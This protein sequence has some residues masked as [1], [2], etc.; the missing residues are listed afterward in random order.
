MKRRKRHTPMDAIMSDAFADEMEEV[1]NQ[2]VQDKL[3]KG[4]YLTMIDVLEDTLDMFSFGR[5]MF[6]PVPLHNSYIPVRHTIMP[7]PNLVDSQYDDLQWRYGR[8]TYDGLNLN[9]VEPFQPLSTYKM[10]QLQPS[11]RKRV[12]LSEGRKFYQLRRISQ[13]KRRFSTV[14]ECEDAD[15]ER[16]YFNE[17][18]QL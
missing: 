10:S 12:N 4:E 8:D 1:Y 9:P 13:I 3:A 14:V 6:G 5:K 18:L 15:Y 17:P 7:K 2:V 16:K 11:L